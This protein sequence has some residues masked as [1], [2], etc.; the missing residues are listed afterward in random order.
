MDRTSDHSSAE[1]PQHPAPAC[2]LQ[3][4]PLGG[5]QLA[6]VITAL[7]GT[8]ERPHDAHVGVAGALSAPPFADLE[9]GIDATIVWRSG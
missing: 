8:L 5:D 3:D 7:E 6:L 1:P 2:S 4:G 9:E